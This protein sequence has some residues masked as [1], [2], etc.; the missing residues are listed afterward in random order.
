MMERYNPEMNYGCD[1]Y[2]T[3]VQ[4]DLWSDGDY[5]LHE[6]VC[7]FL[8]ELLQCDLG[9]LIEKIEEELKYA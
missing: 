7:T 9:T 1:G 3:G 2:P 8:K 6:D 4:M 5:V